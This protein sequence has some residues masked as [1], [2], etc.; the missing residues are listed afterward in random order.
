MPATLDAVKALLQQIKPDSLTALEQQGYSSPWYTF[1]YG[2]V[3]QYWVVYHSSTRKIEA[4]L[5]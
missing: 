5:E 2:G 4:I 1:D 3:D